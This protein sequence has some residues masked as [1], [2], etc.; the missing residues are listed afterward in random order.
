MLCGKRNSSKWIREFIISVCKDKAVLVTRS[1]PRLCVI[2]MICV[3]NCSLTPPSNTNSTLI[4]TCLTVKS[5]P[6]NPQGPFILDVTLRSSRKH[7]TWSC[8]LRTWSSEDMIRTGWPRSVRQGVCFY[9]L[10]HVKAEDSWVKME[11][12]IMFR[13]TLRRYASCQLVHLHTQA[14]TC[15][16]FLQAL[17]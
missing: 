3:Q 14:H 10:C 4:P 2:D 11:M 7:K 13:S 1:G 5:H 8:Q 15:F 6:S 16:L 9:F 17:H 12:S